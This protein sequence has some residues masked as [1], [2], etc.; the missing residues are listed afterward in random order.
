[1]RG[2]FKMIRT[3]EI[4]L[5]G[6]QIVIRPLN[7]KYIGK[8]FTVLKKVAGLKEDSPPE[9]LMQSLDDEAVTAL[10]I[11]ITET[12]RKANIGVE[13]DELEELAS[14]NLFNLMGPILEINM[15]KQG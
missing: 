14:Q 3:K 5:E 9:E 8:M 13:G 10:H 4:E 2:Y 12:L 1:M 6:K 15:P 7:G 11:V